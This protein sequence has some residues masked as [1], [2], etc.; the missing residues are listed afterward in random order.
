[1]LVSE[2]TCIKLLKLLVIFFIIHGQTTVQENLK[3][4]EGFLKNLKIKGHIITICCKT[5]VNE[6][7]HLITQLGASERCVCEDT[8]G[9]SVNN[10][11]TELICKYSVNFCVYVRT[12][13]FVELAYSGFVNIC[14]T[15]E[16][17]LATFS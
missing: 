1:M 12:K 9:G 8:E 14:T 6:R 17:R 3:L 7:L 16:R 10:K 4:F 5:Q 13:C 15:G 11:Y 2:F